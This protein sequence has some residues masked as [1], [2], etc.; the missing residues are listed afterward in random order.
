M[1]GYKTWAVGEEVLA[2]DLNSYLQSQAVA[3]FPN[4]GTRTAQLPAPGLNQL[5]TLDAAPGRVDFWTGAVW[6]PIPGTELGYGERTT[7]LPIGV[8]TDASS[9]VVAST[10]AITLDGGP[11]LLEFFAPQVTL[12]AGV[13]SVFSV[14]F[15]E[16]NVSLGLASATM[17]VVAGQGTVPVNAQ[18]RLPVA[19][20]SHSYAARAACNAGSAVVVA[21]TGGAG[22]TM[23]AFIRVTRA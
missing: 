13:G 9:L 3:R 16:D 18:R 5:S 4:A 6:A 21:G 23:P 7:S 22:T 11:I 8:G 14:W 10:P 17:S 20:G 19:A 2:V 12:P 15:F 1:A